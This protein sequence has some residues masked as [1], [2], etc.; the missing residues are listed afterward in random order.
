M[1]EKYTYK[2]YSLPVKRLHFEHTANRTS[3]EK[4]PLTYAK[5]L[6]F[7]NTY[8]LGIEVFLSSLNKIPFK[9]RFSA[10]LLELT[11]RAR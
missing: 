10:T 8:P 2:T 7:V 6:H 9:E 4:L 11:S 3:T 5:N 1:E